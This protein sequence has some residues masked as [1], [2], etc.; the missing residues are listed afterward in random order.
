MAMQMGR[1][2]RVKKGIS[3]LRGRGVSQVSHD[4]KYLIM[5]VSKSVVDTLPYVSAV[6]LPQATIFTLNLSGMM[7]ETPLTGSSTC[8]SP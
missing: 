8:S 4:S 5:A 1:M 7:V 3:G 6:L 2:P